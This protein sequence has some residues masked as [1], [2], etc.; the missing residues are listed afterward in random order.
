[1][2]EESMMWSEA[3]KI[4]S[5]DSMLAIF[6]QIMIYFWKA[7]LDQNFYRSRSFPVAVE[8]VRLRVEH[9]F[10]QRSRYHVFEIQGGEASGIWDTTPF[11]VDFSCFSHG[12]LLDHGDFRHAYQLFLR[13]FLKSLKKQ[14]SYHPPL[15]LM[16]RILMRLPILTWKC[17]VC[18]KYNQWSRD[19]IEAQLLEHSLSIAPSTLSYLL[20][21]RNEGLRSSTEETVHRDQ[22]EEF[23]PIL[24]E[25]LRRF[26][27]DFE[28]IYEQTSMDP[29]HI[30]K[31]LIDILL[32][33]ARPFAMDDIEKYETECSKEMK[34][35]LFR[36]FKF[37]K[38]RTLKVSH[39]PRTMMILRE[40]FASV[41]HIWRSAIDGDAAMTRRSS[42][43]TVVLLGYLLFHDPVLSPR[44]PQQHQTPL[45]VTYPKSIDK[46]VVR[47]MLPPEIDQLQDYHPVL[48]PYLFLP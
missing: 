1:M 30:L 26:F 28:K 3:I 45:L 43:G 6:W 42:P 40:V 15:L 33:H 37:L 18:K 47:P 10:H 20:T 39:F 21:Y 4:P 16:K 17:P 5:P 36:Q 31:N 48:R 2:E 32:K 12:N 29:V 19:F 24:T 7:E 8:D 27:T 9:R 13:S 34:S 25:T 38:T 11:S 23:L 22:L 41:M 46:P 35:Y 14:A 44:P